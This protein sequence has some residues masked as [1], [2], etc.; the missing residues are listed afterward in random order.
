MAKYEGKVRIPHAISIRRS[1]ALLAWCVQAHIARMAN[2]ARMAA[3]AF[4]RSRQITVVE[5]KHARNKVERP[6]VRLYVVRLLVGWLKCQPVY[7]C[8]MPAQSQL[9][10]NRVD[11]MNGKQIAVARVDR[12]VWS[13]RVREE[14]MGGSKGFRGLTDENGQ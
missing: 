6:N 1:R 3:T 4:F 8:A 5:Q 12:V 13:D 11:G 7:L 2:A 10:I 9:A 14:R